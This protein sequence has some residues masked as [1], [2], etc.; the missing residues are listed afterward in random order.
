MAN[1]QDLK[2]QMATVPDHKMNHDT[3]MNQKHEMAGKMKGKSYKEA[4]AERKAKSNAMKPTMEQ[5][6]QRRI[7][8]AYND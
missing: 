1:L 4:T 3:P 6:Y 5:E 8:R 2:K 7:G